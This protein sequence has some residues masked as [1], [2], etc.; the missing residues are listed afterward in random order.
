MLSY[1]HEANDP[2]ELFWTPNLQKNTPELAYAVSKAFMRSMKHWYRSSCCYLHPPPRTFQAVKIMFIVPQFSLKPHY[3]SDRMF[4]ATLMVSFYS[5]GVAPSPTC[6]EILCTSPP[7]W[8]SL[9]SIPPFPGAFPIIKQLL[10][11]S[12][13][14]HWVSGWWVLA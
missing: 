3:D 14:V 8:S 13:V 1:C 12:R 10:C 11:H 7:C 2:R 6:C 4:S 5:W 9:A